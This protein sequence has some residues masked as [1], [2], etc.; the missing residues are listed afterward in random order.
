MSVVLNFEIPRFTASGKRVTRRKFITWSGVGILVSFVFSLF[1]R[2]ETSTA[3]P[4]KA[5]EKEKKKRTNDE[6]RNKRKNR[7]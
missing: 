4:E 6:T 7:R 2:A 1:R 3:T 5:G